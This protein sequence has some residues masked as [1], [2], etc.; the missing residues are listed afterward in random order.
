[1]SQLVFSIVT[2]SLKIKKWI[3]VSCVHIRTNRS[4]QEFHISTH[5]F[6]LAVRQRNLKDFVQKY[7]KLL[8][9]RYP[10]KV[11]HFTFHVI[12]KYQIYIRY[13]SGYTTN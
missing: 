10:Q 8:Y 9:K 3:V 11:S 1:M 5:L 12:V 2:I 13:I 4:Q 7:Q 6:G